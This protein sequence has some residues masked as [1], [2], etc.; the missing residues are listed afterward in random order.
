MKLTQEERESLQEFSNSGTARTLV[1]WLDIVV[2]R[3]ER[4]VINC[5]VTSGSR[6]IT[7]KKARLEGAQ[8][9]RTAVDTLKQEL[10][11]A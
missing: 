3:M 2:A 1:K 7:L 8:A 10:K 5:P 4:S 9:L 6:E 11:N